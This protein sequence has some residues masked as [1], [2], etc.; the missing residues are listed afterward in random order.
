M[1]VIWALFALL[2]ALLASYL[3]LMVVRR[4]WQFSPLLDGWLVIGFQ[5]VA[6][7]LC[8]AS[9]RGMRRHRRVALAMG[10][11]C[12]SWTI[13]DVAYTIESLGGATPPTFSAADPFFFMFYP[14]ALIAILLFL[15]GEIT[16]E[17]APNWLDGGIAA[18]GIAALCSSFALRGIEHLL[19]R[20]SLSSLVSLSF[21]AADVALL[22]IVVGSTVFVSG[23]RRATL[24]LVAM[25]IALNAAGDTVF[26]IQ[27]ASG[28]SQFSSVLNALAWPSSIWLFAM[29]MWFADRGSE[30]L[31]LQRLSGFGLPGLLAASSL[32]LLILDNWRHV[33]PLAV[34][35][36]GATLLLAGVRLAFRPA[37][38]LARA[39]LRSSEERYRLLFEQNPLPM[40]TYDRKTRQIVA[41]SNAMVASYGYSAAEL[42][43][44]TVDELRAGDAM[45]SRGPDSP[46]E[47]GDAG[48]S[49][50]HAR[51]ALQHRRKDGA[52]IDVEVSSD[53]VSLDGRDCVIALYID[54]TERNR[55]AAEVTAAHDR[56]V[57][58]SNMKSAFLA[59]VSHEI[60]TPMNAVIGM[61]ELL[62]DLDLT[63]KQREYAEQVARS[64]DQMLALINDVLDL[65]KIE[66]G[67][68][69]L[70]FDNFELVEMI[71]QACATA[72]VLADSKQLRLE[73]AISEDVPLRARGDGRRLQQVLA[74]LL[75]NAIKFTPSGAIAVRVGTTQPAAETIALRV[76]V[77]DTGIG[78]DPGQLQRM[79]E[80]FT[81]ADVS[82][83]RVYGGTG[84]G[85]AIAREMIEMMGG[86]IDARSAP[87]Q[88]S[89]FWFDVE[90]EAPAAAEALSESSAAAR[91]ASA[92][93]RSDSPL[94]LLAEDS[95]VNQIVARRALE[96]CGCSVE[97]VATG[98]EALRA[99]AAGHYD[100][101]LMDCQMPEMD[102]YEATREFRRR[103]EASARTPVIAMTAHAMTG[104]RERCIDAG[105]DDYITKPVRHADLESTLRRWLGV[106]SDPA[107][108][109]TDAGPPTRAAA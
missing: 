32:G 52:I 19:A 4:S 76:E 45:L 36:A 3:G 48:G 70:E 65:S 86:T 91:R 47:R 8:F 5:T 27:P 77:S 46:A 25:G 16:R 69:E 44:M 71:E 58:A 10:A 57:E 42:H 20:P 1:V 92:S 99:L 38:R 54:V 59:N 56:A 79:F 87:G 63:G 108:D 105:M 15:G 53:D 31:A 80:P 68:I 107:A 89:T 9:A 82:T 101:V 50:A 11:A 17:D 66:T 43:A 90:L 103:E 22:G 84:L 2:G 83:T 23:R 78:I 49:G 6:C 39:Q 24:V 51:D 18:L 75:S 67:H 13:G 73:L 96:R 98:T 29:A 37:L 14:L 104:D 100:A 34:A 85:L 55:M 97:V 109:D 64:G 81:Q 41:A 95:P 93:P 26:F 94:V 60:R 30:R 102:G 12:A 61:T 106:H 35:L 74:N 88:G 7:G 40:V 62:L 33:P 21:P 72:G 28:A